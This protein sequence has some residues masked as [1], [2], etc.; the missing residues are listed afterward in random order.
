[1][2]VR[3]VTTSSLDSLGVSENAAFS[4][5][6]SDSNSSALVFI[7]VIE[8]EVS[9]AGRDYIIR[10]GDCI[11]APEYEAEVGGTA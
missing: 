8:G 3:I 9:R 4:T 5:S 6:S 11:P 2:G 10:G 1:M 7:Y